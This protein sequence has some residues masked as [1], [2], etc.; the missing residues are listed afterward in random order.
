MRI[1]TLGTDHRQQYDFTRLLY[2]YSIQVVFD[3]RRTPE[4]REEHF[5]RGPLEAL[6]TQNH[7]DYVFI[8][9]ELGGPADGDLRT[10]VRSDEFKRGV[11]IIARKVP[12]R[13][14]C[15]LC[16]ERTPEHCHRL[17]IAG[18]LQAQGIEVRHL[19]DDNSFWTPRSPRNSAPWR[20]GRPAR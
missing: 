10:W 15:V 19:L 14:C 3:V 1:Y 18:A 13:V 17:A 7:V 12:N 6:L 4:A 5:C 2:K 16:A 11:A 9:N 8:G 20:R